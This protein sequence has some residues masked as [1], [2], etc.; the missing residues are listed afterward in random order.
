MFFPPEPHHHRPR[1]P[2]QVPVTLDRLGSFMM[3]LVRWTSDIVVI[4]CIIIPVCKAGG[5]DS[6]EE[7]EQFRVK[8]SWRE[9]EVSCEERCF[10]LESEVY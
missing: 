7:M 5:C 6:W 4:E 9:K 3:N 10:F 2:D 1:L 8:F